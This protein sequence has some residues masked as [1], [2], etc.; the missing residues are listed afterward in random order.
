MLLNE[1]S[2]LSITAGSIGFIH[3]VFGPDHYLPF[4]VMSKARNWSTVKTFWITFL[5][6]SGH[7]LSSVLLGFIGITFGIAVTKLTAVESFRGEIAAWAFIAFGLVYFIWGMR[8]ALRNRT[9]THLHAHAAKTEHSH[10]HDHRNDHLHVHTKAGIKELTPWILFIIFVL[11]PCEPLIPLLMYPAAK[12]SLVGVFLVAG[13]F[14]GVTI[15]TMLGI[16]MFSSSGFKF[17][18]LGHLK[19][20]SHALAGA[21]ILLSGMAIRLMGLWQTDLSET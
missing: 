12:S 19:R 5:C 13:I 7:I 6:G 18:P 10:E 21:T 3:T 1:I 15:S 14:G 2:I 9:H 4:I 16:V 17:L 20:Y 8:R 11:G